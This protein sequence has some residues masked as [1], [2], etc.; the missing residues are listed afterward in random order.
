MH[1]KVSRVVFHD[2]N[3]VVPSVG[4]FQ[5][6]LP[7]KTKD[8]KDLSMVEGENG[9]EVTVGSFNATIPFANCKIWFWETS[10]NAY[11]APIK[12]KAKV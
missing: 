2:V 10:S 11:E 7:S 6:E 8:I 4:T 9:I 12:T 1:K 5:T 3:V